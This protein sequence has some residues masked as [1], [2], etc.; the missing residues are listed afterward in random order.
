MD[1]TFSDDGALLKSHVLRAVL[2]LSGKL[3][4]DGRRQLAATAYC[5]HSFFDAYLKRATASRLNISSPLY[6]RSRFSIV[7][8][9]R[10]RLW[11]VRFLTVVAQLSTCKHEGTFPSRERSANAF[12]LFQHSSRLHYLAR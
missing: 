6:P 4:I 3:G 7:W 9:M 10:K 5:V 8:Q 12:W 1:F 2:R 11:R